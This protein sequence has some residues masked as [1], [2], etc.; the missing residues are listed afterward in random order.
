MPIKLTIDDL[1]LEQAKDYGNYVSALCPWHEDHTPSLLVYKDGWATCLSCGQSGNFYQL[2]QALQGWK[3]VV[4]PKQETAWRPP[5]LPTDKAELECFAD[6][7][8]HTLMKFTDT[9]GWYLHE[10]GVEDRIERCKLGW[11]NGWITIP[12]YTKGDEFDGLILRALPHVQKATGARFHQPHGQKGMPYVPDWRLLD[13]KKCIFVVFGMFDALVLNSIGLP[14]MTTTAGK[15]SF[16]VDWVDGYRKRIIFVPDKGEETTADKY[17]NKLG[18]RGSVLKLD[19]P[20]DM[21][22]PADYGSH[23]MKQQLLNT[24]IG[25]T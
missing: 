5:F 11:H 3:A 25:Y 1:P 19:Y 15:D 24:L 21:K 16:K 7:A 17:V 12:V 4:A 6:D 20:E 8:H 2:Y 18:W 22:D 10:R 9:L 23:D 13:E 14:V